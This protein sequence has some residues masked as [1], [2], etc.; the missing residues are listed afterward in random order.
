MNHPPNAAENPKNPEP[1]IAHRTRD[2]TTVTSVMALP[3]LDE[4]MGQL[5]DYCQPRKHPN[6]A[7]TWT[8]SYS[9]G[10]GRLF[11]GIGSNTEGTGKLVEGAD[12]FFFVHYDDIPIARCKD[13]T[14]IS[15]VCEVCPQKEDPNRTRT[16]IGGNRICYPGD[17]GTPTAS[18]E[19]FKLLINSVLSRKGAHF[20]C[21]DINNFYL[22]TPLDRPKYAR[23]HLKDTPQKF[24]TK[25]NLTTYVRDGWVYFRI[26]KGVYGLP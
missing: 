16:T 8:T 12:T 1:P 10:M 9:N 15:F 6:Y 22:G 5:M 18:L 4:E 25:Y 2:H 24:I 3:V 20:V 19:I 7:A 14:Y 17:F 26:C 13:T 21:F 23:I 11:Q